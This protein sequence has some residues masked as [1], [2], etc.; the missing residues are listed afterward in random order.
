MEQK[1]N[2]SEIRSFFVN[3]GAAPP[4]PLSLWKPR[5]SRTL[6][7]R[8]RPVIIRRAEGI[9][10]PGGGACDFPRLFPEQ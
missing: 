6:A 7:V 9:P 8:A 4:E 3:L 5:Q 2:A 10:V 1:W